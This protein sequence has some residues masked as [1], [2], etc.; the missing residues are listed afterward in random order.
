MPA[1]PALLAAYADA[2]YEVHI[3]SGVETLL[4]GSNTSPLPPLCIITAHNPGPACQTPAENA[5]ANGELQRLLEAR[6]HRFAESLARDDRG[7]H[8]EPGFAVFG[9]DLAEALELAHLFRQAA[10]LSWDGRQA[11]VVPV[12]AESP[13]GTTT[14]GSG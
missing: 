8:A 12:E 13:L 2:I 10:I 1:D 14:P 7:A 4:V 3:P 6:G 9:I 11:R 5:W